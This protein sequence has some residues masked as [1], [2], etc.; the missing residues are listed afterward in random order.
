[1]TTAAVSEK[2][3]ITLPIEIRRKLGLKPRSRVEFQLRDGEVVLRRQMTVRE[4]EGIFAHRP[5]AGMT[6]EKEIEMMEEAVAREV[7]SE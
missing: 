6:H 4:L 5:I 1:M 7:M 3:Q 2:G